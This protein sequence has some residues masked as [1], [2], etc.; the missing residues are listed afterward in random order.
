M[1]RR[2]AE[3]GVDPFDEGF[4]KQI[5]RYPRVRRMVE[6]TIRRWATTTQG[7]RQYRVEGRPVAVLATTFRQLIGEPPQY[8][9]WDKRGIYPRKDPSTDTEGK[10]ACA[11]HPGR[12]SASDKDGDET[13]RAPRRHSPDAPDRRRHEATRRSAGGRAMRRP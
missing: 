9:L 4:A 1:L 5:A 10:T 2:M 7:R 3:W 11:A 6:D 13:K 12:R 8:Y